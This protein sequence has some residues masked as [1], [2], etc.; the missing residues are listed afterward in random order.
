MKKRSTQAAALT[1]PIFRQRKKPSGKG[2][3][4]VK[5]IQVEA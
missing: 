2:Y 1:K 3:K 4:R 5:R